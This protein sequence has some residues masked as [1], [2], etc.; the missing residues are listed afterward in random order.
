MLEKITNFFEQNAVLWRPLKKPQPRPRR[1]H[2]VISSDGKMA[3]RVQRAK[4]E[5]YYFSRRGA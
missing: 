5:K 4:S 3:V 1:V 2:V